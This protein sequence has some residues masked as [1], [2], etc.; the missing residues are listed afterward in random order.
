MRLSN[1]LLEASEEIKKVIVTLKYPE[2]DIRRDYHGM[3]YDVV[4]NYYLGHIAYE[5]AEEIVKGKIGF[6]KDLLPFKTH[7]DRLT[8]VQLNSMSDHEQEQLRHLVR[9][10]AGLEEGL[11]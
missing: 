1:Y 10:A 9:F 5:L 11:W 2:D 4:D 6:D 8:G 3:I 7:I